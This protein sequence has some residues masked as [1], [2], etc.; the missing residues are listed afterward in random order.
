M[1][2]THTHIHVPDSTSGILTGVTYIQKSIY[3]HRKQELHKKGFQLY[4]ATCAYI[5]SVRE[6]EPE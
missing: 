4:A 1:E 3:Q 5:C 6:S 2:I